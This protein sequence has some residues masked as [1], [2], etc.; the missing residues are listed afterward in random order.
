M[1]MVAAASRQGAILAAV[2]LALIVSEDGAGV[3]AQA[4]DD[5]P[6]VQTD[7]GAVRGHVRTNLTEWLGIPYAAAPVGP[8]RWKAPRPA[9]SWT[10]VRDATTPGR[11]CVQGTGW[12]P[13]Y[14]KPTLTEDCLFINVYR[15]NRAP[16][17]TEPAL[18]PVLVWIHGGGLTGGAGYD[19]DPRKFVDLGQ[20]VFV[21]FNYRLGAMGFLAVP[22]LRQEDADAVGNYGLLDQQAA[23]RWVHRNI[24]RFGGD[25]DQVTLAG[26]SAGASSVCDQLASPA[27]KGLFARAIHQSGGCTMTS[28]ALAEETGGRFAATLGCIDPSTVAVCLR[29]KSAADILAA[30]GEVRVATPVYGGAL[31]PTNPAD[32]V[33][34]GAFNRVPILIGQVHD[35][36][37]QSQFAASDY[38]G[39][40]VTA[41]QYSD[42]IRRRHGARAAAVLAQYPVTAFWSPTVALATVEGDERSCQRQSLIAQFG[43]AVPTFAYEFDEQDGPPFVSVWRLHSTFRFGATHVNDLGYLFDYLRQALPF[44]AAQGELSDQ[45][46]RYWSTFTRTGDPNGPFVPAWPKYE[47]KSEAMLSLQAAGTKIKTDFAMDHRCGFWAAR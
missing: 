14:E 16:A 21:T 20:V 12:D 30:Q 34:A 36:R 46:I 42:E 44:S 9:A 13:G 37:T 17:T 32:A 7:Q 22:D 3:L 35:E 25:P 45:M 43:A 33:R 2:V 24:L 27:V 38:V 31:F 15:P 18:L 47:A 10:G 29:S 5:A 40:P 26:Q 23:L 1:I 28:R 11:A 4:P 8:L 19:T 39:K 41:A 6:V